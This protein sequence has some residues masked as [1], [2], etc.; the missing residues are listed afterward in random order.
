M[1]L[2]RHYFFIIHIMLVKLSRLA[3]G[4]RAFQLLLG[5]PS[6]QTC[7]KFLKWWFSIY[8]LP[9][10]YRCHLHVENASFQLHGL[11]NPKSGYIKIDAYLQILC[12]VISDVKLSHCFCLS[13]VKKNVFLTL[14]SFRKQFQNLRSSHYL[15]VGELLRLNKHHFKPSLFL[16]FI[17]VFRSLNCDKNGLRHKYFSV[18]VMFSNYFVTKYRL[19]MLS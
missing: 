12:H 7:N 10:L 9:V 11:L 13:K 5:K 8:I 3:L 14:K 19:P 4:G 16:V 2:A 15:N 17:C 1:Q 6:R 18:K